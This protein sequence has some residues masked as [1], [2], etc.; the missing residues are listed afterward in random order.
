LLTSSDIYLL[1]LL[2]GLHEVG[3][4]QFAHEVLLVMVL[5]ILAFNMAWPSFL[6]RSLSDGE[7]GERAVVRIGHVYVMSLTGLALAVALFA[8][9]ALALVGGRTYAESGSVVPVLALSALLYAVYLVVSSG[10]YA[11][12]ATRRLPAIAL[13][14]AA[15]NILL[16]LV[17]IPHL[18]YVGAGMASAGANLVLA[19][20][21]YLRA[22]SVRPIRFPIRSWAVAGAA[23]VVLGAISLALPDL[24][25]SA[26]W[27][28]K[29]ICLA[30]GIGLLARGVRRA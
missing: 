12:K 27:G 2:A 18:G 22:Q 14:A 28:L 25:G 1:K 6:Y 5:P 15:V 19:V 7:A 16:D 9:E 23:C 3:Q 8:P 26:R 11:A 10:L 20:L 21:A 4:Y 29:V 17:W 30:A 13:A 24:T